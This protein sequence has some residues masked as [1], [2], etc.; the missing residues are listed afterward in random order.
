LIVV[1]NLH[2]YFQILNITATPAEIEI[3]YFFI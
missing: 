1:K 3:P 2:H